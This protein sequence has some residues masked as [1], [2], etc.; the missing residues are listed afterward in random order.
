MKLFRGTE[1]LVSSRFKNPVVTIGNF[2]SKICA[3]NLIKYIKTKFYRAMLSTK[4]VTQGNKNSKVFENIPLLD[5]SESSDIP[6]DKSI[7]DID[8]FLFSKFRLNE[9]EIKFI[10]ENVEEMK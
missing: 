4:K 6:W 8:N 2:D 7:N 9:N 5:F 3:D 10:V 1:K